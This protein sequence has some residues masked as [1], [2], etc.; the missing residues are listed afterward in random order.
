MREDDGE[1]RGG[2]GVKS[3]RYYENSKEGYKVDIGRPPGPEEQ[4]QENSVVTPVILTREKNA[5]EA[6]PIASANNTVV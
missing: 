6:K 5:T 2:F 1:Y 3:W 4:N